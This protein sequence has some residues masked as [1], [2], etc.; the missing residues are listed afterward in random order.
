MAIE[1]FKALGHPLRR[2]VLALLRQGPKTS[3]ELAE[4]FEATWPTVTRHLNVLKEAELITAER[5][6]TSIIY[7]ANTS[8]M[9][10]AVTSLME[11]IGRDNGDDELKEAAE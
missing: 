6:G 2:Q 9:E 11:L 5:Q 7:R 4:A 1:V 10:D 8:V 3:G